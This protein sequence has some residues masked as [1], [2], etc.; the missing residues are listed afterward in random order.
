[1]NA[2]A[3]MSCQVI[4]KALGKSTAFKKVD[5]GLYVVKQGPIVDRDQ[6]PRLASRPRGRSLLSPSWSRA[7]T[8]ILEAIG[9]TPIVKLQKVA[10]TSPPTSTSSAST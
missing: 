5:E 4:E 2:A 6:R 9:N 8:N 10:R 7:L 3:K 1:M